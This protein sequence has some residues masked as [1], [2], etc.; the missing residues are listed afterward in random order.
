MIEIF[1]GY[2]V[3]EE[4]YKHRFEGVDLQYFR[5]RMS[6]EL[7]AAFVKHMGIIEG[8]GLLPEETSLEDE[9]EGRL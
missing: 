4:E 2:E 8:Y 1:P 3:S 9:Y 6:P 7:F 5:H